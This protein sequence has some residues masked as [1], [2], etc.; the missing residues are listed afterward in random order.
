MCSYKS[1][2]IYIYI[3]IYKILFYAFTFFIINIEYLNQIQL[4]LSI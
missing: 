4:N 1:E 2:Y 3:Y